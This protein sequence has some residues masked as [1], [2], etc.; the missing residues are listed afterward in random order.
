MGDDVHS[1]SDELARDPASLAFLPLGEVLRREGR[2]DQAR[3][4]VVRG[5]ERHPHLPDAHDL[6]ARIYADEG[7]PEKAFD[8][9]DMVRRLAPGHP[10]AAK[11]MGFICFREGRL[12]E[13]ERYLQEAQAGAPADE[14]IAGA[15][16]MVRQAIAD[17]PAV[18]EPPTIAMPA[19]RMPAAAAEDPRFLFTAV[20]TDDDQTALLLDRDGLVLAG[21]YHTWDGRD[22][23]QDVGAQLSGVSDEAT[24]A[25]R[26]L[27]IGAWRSITF[28]AEAA[29]VAMAP[30]ADDGLLVLAAGRATPLGLTRRLLD[31]CAAHARAWMEGGA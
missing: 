13:A 7:E 10:D 17:T 16:A 27:G 5:L 21:A 29:M 30:T 26:H 4:I 12:P 9:W 28:E 20:L 8:E 15:L 24:R 1:L 31:R 23:A 19:M 11:G 2:L 22:I 18:A 14:R 6:L 25:T 3:R